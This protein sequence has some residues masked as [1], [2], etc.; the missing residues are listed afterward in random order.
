MHNL[1]GNSPTRLCS[2][3]PLIIKLLTENIRVWFRFNLNR[4]CF[5]IRLRGGWL[6]WRWT[7]IDLNVVRHDW[8]HTLRRQ[9]QCGRTA[10]DCFELPSNYKRDE[11]KCVRQ[12]NV[13]VKAGRIGVSVRNGRRTGWKS[14][15][16]AHWLILSCSPNLNIAYTTNMLENAS[17]EQKSHVEQIWW[18]N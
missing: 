16:T 13:D 14:S 12:S 6:T 5:S 9:G 18:L 1:N 7:W 15:T 17:T 4:L 11:A 2:S 10:A 8:A 3:C